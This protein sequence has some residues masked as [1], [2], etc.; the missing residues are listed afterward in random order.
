[1]DRGRGADAQGVAPATPY[2]DAVVE[3]GAFGGR[4][5]GESDLQVGLDRP[6]VDR[7]WTLGL[8]GVDLGDAPHAEGFEDAVP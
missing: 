2:G 1:M 6:A 5:G 8:D 3:R 7:P 4:P